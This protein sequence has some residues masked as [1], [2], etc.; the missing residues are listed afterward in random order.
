MSEFD[1]PIDQNTRRRLNFGQVCRKFTKGL[2][3]PECNKALELF[4]KAESSPSKVE[5]EKYRNAAQLLYSKSKVFLN[6]IDVDDEDKSYPVKIFAL[7]PSTYDD[8]ITQVKGMKYIQSNFNLVHP[9]IGHNVLITRTGTGRNTRYAVQIDQR[10]TVLPNSEVLAQL[11]GHDY[12]PLFDLDVLEEFIMQNYSNITTPSK[13]LNVIRFL[14]P[15]QGKK[16]VYRELR[17]HRF[18]V[19][20]YKNFITGSDNILGGTS[21]GLDGPKIPASDD[22]F[23]PFALVGETVRS[24]NPVTVPPIVSTPKP[25]EVSPVASPNIASIDAQIKE[26]LL[27]KQASQ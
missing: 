14:P 26:L 10:E 20:S 7:A 17:F 3:C 6:G 15:M 21:T 25:V 5:G 13:A 18:T 27:K 24:S 19:D 16:A 8:I 23:D 4:K 1:F 9:Q 2:D 11:L 22:E 12:S